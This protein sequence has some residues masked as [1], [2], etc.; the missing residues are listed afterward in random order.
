MV[1][2]LPTLVVL[3]KEVIQGIHM[4]SLKE[5]LAVGQ[6]DRLHKCIL[7]I[8]FLGLQERDPQNIMELKEFVIHRDSLPTASAAA[9]VSGGWG[10]WIQLT[11]E[12]ELLSKI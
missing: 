9:D 4:L 12:V 7:F 11:E 8:F 2:S 5:L 1:V 10:S 6:P 3:L